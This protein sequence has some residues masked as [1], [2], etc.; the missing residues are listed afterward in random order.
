MPLVLCLVAGVLAG[1]RAG[2]VLRSGCE[3]SLRTGEA[4]R[5][6]GRLFA[7]ADATAG[8]RSA[9]HRVGLRDVTI[10]AGARSCRV[11]SLT[12]FLEGEIGAL[13]AGEPI[14][15]G[16]TWIRLRPEEGAWPEPAGHAGIVVEA[17]REP[18]GAGGAEGGSPV[19]EATAWPT[20]LRTAASRR[21][22]GGLPADVRPTARALL[23][24][25]RDEL[26]GEVRRRFADAGLAHLLAISG[27]HIGI[28]ATLVLA[29]VSTVARGAARPLAAAAIV[30]SYVVAIGAPAPAARAGLVFAGWA[31]GRARGRP[32][33]TGDLAGVAALAALV[34]APASIVEPGFQLSFAGFGGVVLAAGAVGARHGRPRSR[35]RRGA[36]LRKVA[37]SAVLVASTGTGAFLATAPIAAAHFGRVAPVSLVSHFAGTPLVALAILGLCASLLPGL[38][39]GLGADAATLAIR[40]LHRFAELMAGLPLGHGASLP[41]GPWTW[42]AWGA[43]WVALF[44]WSGSGRSARALVPAALALFFLLAGPVAAR[45]RPAGNAL[46][47]TLAVGQGD[48]ALL[49]TPGRRWI[50]FDGGP[51]A[52]AG[53]G[54]E[55]LASGLR[56]RGA[57][58]VA[59]VVLSHPDLDHLAGLE[60]VVTGFPVGALLDSGDA[61]PREAYARLL[62]ALDARGVPWIEGRA[63]TRLTVDGVELHVLGPPVEERPAIGRDRDGGSAGPGARANATSLVVRVAVGRFRYLNPGDATQAEEEDLLRAWPS[64]SLRADLLKVGHHGSRTSSSAEWLAAVRPT[65]AAISAGPG[66]R[67]GHPHAE[68]LRRLAAAGVGEVWRTDHDGSLCVEIE[69]DGSWRKRGESR[70]RDPASAGAAGRHGD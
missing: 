5:V 33:R 12:V 58:A 20:R 18:A 7:D 68:V 67:Y 56:R 23:L 24:A 51:S 27:M 30:G 11:R 21:L 28:L 50:V 48:A 6:V 62:A 64:E 14:R 26:G 36:G 17:R 16:G 29:L 13:R 35:S 55:S 22:S 49:R 38:P 57:R 31:L 4:I 46:L 65:I 8:S 19:E 40:A 52:T 32:P 9:G 60:P 41:P 3:S 69:P 45:L 54:R 1:V 43:G 47:C 2:A 61:L 63:G 10:R 39:G 37:R 15:A 59:L 66:N 53:T 42:L 70:W 25:E 44:R 34:A